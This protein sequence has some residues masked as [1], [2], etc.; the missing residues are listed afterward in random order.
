VRKPA[1]GAVAARVATEGHIDS[2]VPAMTDIVSRIY[3]TA[4]ETA[5]VIGAS[6]PLPALVIAAGERANI[7]FLVDRQR[8]FQGL[9][10]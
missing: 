5:L 1:A 9:W 3:P 7:R 4:R 8:S 6:A 10:F 2:D